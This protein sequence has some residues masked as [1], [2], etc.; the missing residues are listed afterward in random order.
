MRKSKASLGRLSLIDGE[1]VSEL[2]NSLV[3]LSGVREGVDIS[4]LL[5]VGTE[6][7]HEIGRETFE[8]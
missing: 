4:E 1:V 7:W 5:L 6:R 8:G 2:P 3:S